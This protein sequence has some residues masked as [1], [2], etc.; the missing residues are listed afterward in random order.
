MGVV[1]LSWCLS[2]VSISSSSVLVVR[3]SSGSWATIVSL[4]GAILASLLSCCCCFLAWSVRLLLKVRTRRVF[5]AY[6]LGSSNK[7]ADA[8]LQRQQDMPSNSNDKRISRR[9]L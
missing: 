6:R 5:V 8:L 1:G 9:F 2:S 3:R 4:S 7:R